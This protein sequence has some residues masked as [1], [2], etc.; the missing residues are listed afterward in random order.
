MAG[1]HEAHAQVAQEGDGVGPV[2]QQQRLSDAVALAQHPADHQRGA[3]RLHRIV[4]ARIPEPIQRGEAGPQRVALRHHPES[5]AGAGAGPHLRGHRRHRWRRRQ[6]EASGKDGQQATVEQRQVERQARRRHPGQPAGRVRARR[7]WAWHIAP[8]RRGDAGPRA[9]RR[10]TERRGGQ[11]G[12]PGGGQPPCPLPGRPRRAL[13]GEPKSP[14]GRG[15]S[16]DPAPR[17]PHRKTLEPQ[18]GGDRHRQHPDQAQPAVGGVVEQR[19]RPDQ[20]E[21]GGDGEGR[22]QRRRAA[23][24]N[25]HHPPAEGEGGGGG[26]GQ[27]EQPG[28]AAAQLVEVRRTGPAAAARAAVRQGIDDQVQGRRREGRRLNSPRRPRDELGAH[29]VRER[30]DERQQ[31]RRRQPGAHRGR[32][33]QSSGIA[34]ARRA[35]T[36]GGVAAGTRR[37]V[38]ANPAEQQGRR[39]GAGHQRGVNERLRMAGEGHAAGAGGQPGKA[40]ALAAAQQHQAEHDPR[41]PGRRDAERV[42]GPADRVHRER[43]GDGR[44]AGAGTP[45]AESGEQRVGQQQRHE[46][47]ERRHD[48][49]RAHGRQRQREQPEGRERR[50]LGIAEQR[51]AGAHLA[52]PQRRLA[53]QRDVAEQA[54]GRHRRD[55]HHLPPRPPLVGDVGRH[56]QLRGEQRRREEGAGREPVR[57]D[58]APA[59]ARAPPAHQPAEQGAAAQVDQEAHGAAI[60][61][62]RAAA[63][64][65][66]P[67]GLPPLSR[68]GELGARCE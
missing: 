7:R 40:A 58:P 22:G 34:P 6:V 46:E 23:G 49:Q 11:R 1:Q 12:A 35:A 18:A 64:P 55:L 30:L 37:R 65:V 4:G 42:E 20:V 51:L 17:R 29:R 2:H 54:V 9:R 38:A 60:M 44:E 24:E 47:L 8:R 59:R 68:R 14:G 27:G 36:A 31:R 21:E 63:A 25:R 5:H 13:A 15:G 52:G 28:V 32:G 39:D 61:P 48:R 16:R 66:Q 67:G 57:G 50:R 45:G 19:Q 56:L 53:A 26:E 41:Q 33:R 3:R 10:P 43:E 62:A